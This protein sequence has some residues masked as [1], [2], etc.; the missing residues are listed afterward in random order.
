MVSSF[1][2]RYRET[3]RRDKHLGECFTSG[4]FGE[5]IVNNAGKGKDNNRQID[6]QAKQAYS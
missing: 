3:Y 1:E 6:W 5:I 2:I 4:F